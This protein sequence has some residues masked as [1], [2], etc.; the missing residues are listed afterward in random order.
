MIKWQYYKKHNYLWKKQLAIFRSPSCLEWLN[1]LSWIQYNRLTVT[2]KVIVWQ[3][4]NIIKI[5]SKRKLLVILR[6]P[7]IICLYWITKYFPHTWC[8]AFGRRML[9][10]WNVSFFCSHCLDKKTK[11][12]NN[13]KLNKKVRRSWCVVVSFKTKLYTMCAVYIFLI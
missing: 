8:M 12:V 5:A 13:N 10:F 7:F 11:T 9:K 2:N 1:D 6:S 3:D 4:N